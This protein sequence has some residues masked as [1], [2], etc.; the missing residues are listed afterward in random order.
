MSLSSQRHARVA[1]VAYFLGGVVPLLALAVLV[2]RLAPRAGAAELY[3]SESLIALVA[4]IGFLCFASFLLLRQSALGS[5][6]AQDWTGRQLE[7][8]RVASGSLA[9]AQHPSDVFGT[10]TWAAL[11]LTGADASFVFV[12]A[13]PREPLKLA[14]AAGPRAAELASVVEESLRE[15]IELAV[16][17]GRPAVRAPD[18]QNGA[19]AALPLAGMADSSGALVV[20][21]EQTRRG[22]DSTQLGCLT[23]LADQASLALPGATAANAEL[24]RQIHRRAQAEERAHHLANYDSVTGLANRQ[25][26][27]ER[28]E[29]AIERAR[30]DESMV[31]TLFLDLNGFKE[32]N[33]SL[34]HGVGDQLLRRVG[35]RLAGCTRS[36]DSVAHAASQEPHDVSRLGGD[37][38]TVLL[39]GI[40]SVHDAASVARR[41]LEVLEEPFN[42]DGQEVFSGANV[43]IALFPSDASDA[44]GLLRKAELA[45]HRAK[46]EGRGSYQCFAESMNTE[47]ERRIRLANDLRRALERDEFVLFYQPQLDAATLRVVGVEALIRW[48]HPQLGMVSP[49][50][51]ID[52]AEQSG[53]IVR[54]GEWTLE[55]T[56]RQ[57]REW[58]DAGLPPVRVAVNISAQ[59]LRNEGLVECVARS[60]RESRIEPRMLELEITE[61]ATLADEGEA[62]RVLR[63]LKQ[64]G[65][66]IALDDFGTGYSPLTYVK[67]LPVDAVKID[68]SFVAEIGHDSAAEA[69]PKAIIG[70]AHGLNLRVVA[71]G[72]ETET[73]QAFLQ[74][75][76]CDEL[77]GYLLGRPVPP[78]ELA[79]R[80]ASDE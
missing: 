18:E 35:E 58:G 12:R 42:L 30:R 6:R 60:L 59:Q 8:L 10:A 15:L 73:Q 51:F 63:A 70:M 44:D 38:F 80:L 78:E 75:H 69:I 61:N 45:M 24:D 19:A 28:L 41:M 1:S 54:I 77:Q 48:R 47:V 62:L 2:V 25:L 40:T 39:V 31:A 71:E 57:A 65:I 32:V 49:G 43:G 46:Q 36:I 7:S 16:G 23:A 5:Q 67:Q 56:C 37:E 68:C 17:Q 64:M 52:I 20:V 21:H 33:E 29:L 53:L 9:A 79:Q 34:G 72:V 14:E 74:D 13:G 50:E 27:R 55:T 22:F 66:G 11:E 4:S 26:F 76:D 3:T